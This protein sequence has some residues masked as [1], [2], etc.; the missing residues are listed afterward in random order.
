MASFYTRF[1]LKRS[2]LR[3]KNTIKFQPNSDT[4]FTSDENRVLKLG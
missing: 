3:V 4:R 1:S 2:F